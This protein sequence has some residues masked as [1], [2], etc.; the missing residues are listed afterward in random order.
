VE[1]SFCFEK[2]SAVAYGVLVG[3][4]ILGCPFVQSINRDDAV[5]ILFSANADKTHLSSYVG[6]ADTF[7]SGEALREVPDVFFMQKKTF[8]H[9]WWKSLSFYHL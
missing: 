3:S 9:V 8:P 7:S 5:S 1:K 2:G 4:D 6:D